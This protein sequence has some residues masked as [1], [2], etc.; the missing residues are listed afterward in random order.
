VKAVCV[1]YDLPYTT[2]P[3]VRQYLL[4]LRTIMKPALPD[5]FLTATSDD[6]PETAFEDRFRQNENVDRRRRRYGDRAEDRL[7][8]AANTPSPVRP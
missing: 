8:Y 4:A 1:A 7:I 5:R 2:G 3:L 6:A